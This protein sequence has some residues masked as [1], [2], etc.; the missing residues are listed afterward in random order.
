M[1]V[2]E[3]TSATERVV[4]AECVDYSGSHLPTIAA[5]HDIPCHKIEWTRMC[6]FLTVPQTQLCTTNS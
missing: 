5:I 4:V 6:G 2:K 1:F 3:E